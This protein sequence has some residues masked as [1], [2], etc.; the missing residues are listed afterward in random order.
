[1]RRALPVSLGLL[2]FCW[3]GAGTGLSQEAAV[4]RPDPAVLEA[5]SRD[6]ESALA[7][8]PN[9]DRIR[10]AQALIEQVDHA[11]RWAEYRKGLAT[12]ER[13]RPRC[14]VPLLLRCRLQHL[15]ACAN[16]DDLLATLVLLTGEPF[17]KRRSTV[18]ADLLAEET[19]RYT[20]W[21]LPRHSAGIPTAF[22]QLT[23]E[24]FRLVFG[25]LLER[26]VREQRMTSAGEVRAASAYAWLAMVRNPTWMGG[27]VPETP[28]VSPRMIQ[29][30]LEAAAAPDR[31]DPVVH[32]LAAIRALPGG[33]ELDAR[34]DDAD[35]SPT[36]RLAVML[37]IRQAGGKLPTP[38]LVALLAA[39]AGA[40]TETDQA[41]PRSLRVRGHVA[42]LLCAPEDRGIAVAQ[43]ARAG[44]DADPEVVAAALMAFAELK[45]PD[46]AALAKRLL[47]ES[48][49]EDRVQWAC[50]MVVEDCGPSAPALLAGFLQRAITDASRAPL[51]RTVLPWFGQVTGKS[52]TDAGVSDAG[53]WGRAAEAAVAWWT[54]TAQAAKPTPVDRS[55]VEDPSEWTGLSDPFAREG[56]QIPA[57]FMHGT[58]PPHTLEEIID[59][60]AARSAITRAFAE[61]GVHLQADFAYQRDGVAFTATGYDPERRIGFVWATRESMAA[62]AWNP[63]TPAL[64]DPAR[65][66]W[67]ERDALVQRAVRDREF[68]AVIVPS[69]ERFGYRG[70]QYASAEDF[71]V[72]RQQVEA[73]RERRTRAGLTALAACVQEFVAFA[74]SQALRQ[75]PSDSDQ[76][77]NVFP[78]ADWTCES[79]AEARSFHECGVAEPV[80]VA[81]EVIRERIE[82]VFME[83]G[84]ALQRDYHYDR[85]GVAFTVSGY[86]PN[87]RVGYALDVTNDYDAPDAVRLTCE[88]ARTLEARAG[89]THEFVALIHQ[90]PCLF[91]IPY[92]REGEVPP[93]V[94]A[95]YAE[96]DRIPDP[97]RRQTALDAWTRGC[98]RYRAQVQLQR[99]ERRVREYLAWAKLHGAE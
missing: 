74:R 33:A 82:Q 1:M 91:Q 68:I 8:D 10:A 5:L 67:A 13:L 87:A 43:L 75:Y 48:T 46:R 51:I 63:Q 26:T 57:S 54:A 80:G 79:R 50:Q 93:D 71:A 47:A 17:A 49:Q 55:A 11:G 14:A 76:P 65:L 39:P 21:Y 59:A 56:Y 73:D 25:C 3:I 27:A 53:A 69:Q 70:G 84:Y 18:S 83:A 15:H 36:Q 23:D 77:R 34:V 78:A 28:A 38:A 92:G 30:L 85:D 16:Y 81:L 90:V 95:Q 52:W 4:A 6:Y 44:T 86:D 89:T 31:F 97:G 7:A 61:A 29:P 45:G 32:L 62:D 88:E 19:K 37:A 66:S 35:L 12:L 99:I 22:D 42:L 96:I 64:P 60:Q 2:W 20:E 24:Q 98:D 40:G 72:A 41:L 9:A 94:M 58:V